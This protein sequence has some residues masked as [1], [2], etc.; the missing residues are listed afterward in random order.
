MGAEEQESLS[1]TSWDANPFFMFTSAG[2][3]GIRSH[4]EDEEDKD[5]TF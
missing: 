2:V 3:R 4:E 5:L 1:C